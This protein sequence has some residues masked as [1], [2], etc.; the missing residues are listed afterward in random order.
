MLILKYLSPHT[1]P[2]I[3]GMPLPLGFTLHILHTIPCGQ[4]RGTSVCVCVFFQ[5]CYTT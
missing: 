2:L 4:F 3:L 5:I 1:R